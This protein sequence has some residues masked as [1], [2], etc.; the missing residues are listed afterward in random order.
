MNFQLNVIADTN[1]YLNELD[2]L[3]RMV[4]DEYPFFLVLCVMNVILEELD[5]RKSLKETRDAIRFINEH[6]RSPH[7]AVVNRSVSCDRKMSNDD[8][9]IEATKNIESSI[10]ITQD[11]VMSIKAH[12]KRV[13]FILVKSGCYR[14]LRN[15]I[16]TQTGID[17]I[18][19]CRVNDLGK[20]Y[21]LD[22]A[23][24]LLFYPIIHRMH[25]VMGSSFV[26][27]APHRAEDVSFKDLMNI[28]TK[29]FDIFIDT[30]PKHADN[31][32]S[33][34]LRDIDKDTIH[35]LKQKLGLILA[36]FRIT[37]DYFR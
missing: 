29:N 32:I 31:I 36:I 22:R 9:I 18:E 27:F 13:N 8:R 15:Q 20:D 5:H 21:L 1:I 30:L 24:N 34:M 33:K 23:R 25:S 7:L 17:S 10:L 6:L 3:K 19:V 37:D 11:V 35:E 2:L 28:V 12:E 26:H 14:E 16:I 4:D